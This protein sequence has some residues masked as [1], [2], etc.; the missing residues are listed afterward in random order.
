LISGIT[1]NGDRYSFMYRPNL[2]IIEEKQ[3]PPV[4]DVKNRIYYIIWRDVCS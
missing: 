4:T 2:S 3:P 1:V